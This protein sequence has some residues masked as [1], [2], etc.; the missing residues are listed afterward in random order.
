ME[1]KGD[2]SRV[3]PDIIEV[4]IRGPKCHDLTVVDLPGI[5]WSVGTEECVGF[6]T[7]INEL[8]QTYLNNEYCIYRNNLNLNS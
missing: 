4:H 3:A 8:I 1:Y 2:A 6:V 7:D 5:V